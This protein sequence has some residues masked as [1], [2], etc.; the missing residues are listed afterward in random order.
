VH[1]QAELLEV[2]GALEAASRFPRRLN[3]RQ[4][5]TDQ[6]RDDRDHDQKLDQRESG[7]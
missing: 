2:V 3:G 1:C 6:H 5:E 4:Q 7:L